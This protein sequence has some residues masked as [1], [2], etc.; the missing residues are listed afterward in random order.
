MILS[1][2]WKL[3]KRR[4][5]YVLF[6]LEAENCEETAKTVKYRQSE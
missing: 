1:R 4:T 6:A 3:E 2:K 5:E